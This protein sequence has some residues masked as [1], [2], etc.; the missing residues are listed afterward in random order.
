M[1]RPPGIPLAPRDLLILLVLAEGP[2]HGYGIVTA[3]GRYT[4][5]QVPVDPANLYR[6]LRRMLREGWVRERRTDGDAGR[7]EFELTD[8]GH[9][10]LTAEASRLEKVLG[11]ARAVLAPR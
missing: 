3:A 8:L 10:V 4:D 7:R 5:A 9:R 2:S 11:R 1:L 6:V